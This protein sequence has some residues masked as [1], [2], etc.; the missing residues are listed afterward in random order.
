[1]KR[2]LSII[3]AA[4][5]ILALFTIIPTVSAGA[6]KSGVWKY[7]LNSDGTATLTGRTYASGLESGSVDVNIPSALD[8]HTVVAIKHNAFTEG[9]YYIRSVTIPNT[10]KTI[11]SEAFANAWYLKSVKIPS[12]VTKIEY[13]A[14]FD[15]ELKEV[16]IPK[17]VTTIGEQAFGWLNT[18]DAYIIEPDPVNDFTIM[19]YKG[20]AA[21]Q[22]AQENSFKFIKLVATPKI[23]KLE[24]TTAGVR[25]TLGKSAGATKYRIF[26][27]NGKAWVKLADTTGDTYMHKAAKNNTKYKYT[28]RALSNDGKAYISDFNSTGWTITFFAAP[29]PPKLANTKNGVRINVAA[30]AG[31]PIYR[32]FRKTGNT[33]SWKSIAV[34]VRSTK[35]FIDK[36]AKNGVTYRYTLRAM[37]K[38]KQ[39]I[40]SFNS[41]SVIKCKR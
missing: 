41:G 17:S 38:N 23:S 26:T 10:V 24:N 25:I 32:I 30:A 7:E 8:G 12:S 1:M 20:S 34:V 28:I 6:L 14:F 16:A 18:G 22:Y 40:S 9:A 19:G 27:H 21:E 4:A 15:T 2:T 33:G 5:M 31:V 39:F 37:N 36:T 11:G 13:R 35:Y 29:A 3:L